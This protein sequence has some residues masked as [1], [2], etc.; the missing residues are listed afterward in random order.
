MNLGELIRRT[1]TSLLAVAV[2]GACDGGSNASTGPP[3]PTCWVVGDG[4]VWDV[5]WSPNGS[6]L[7]IAI[8]RPDASAVI[9]KVD[10]A[11]HQLTVVDDAE[12][13]VPLAVSVDD[14]G[15][16]F[17]FGNP[18][19]RD[20]IYRDDLGE[21]SWSEFDHG[22]VSRAVE[23]STSGLYL[24]RAE[25]VG[26]SEEVT[27]SKVDVTGDVAVETPLRRWFGGSGL[28]VSA[29]GETVL[30]AGRPV[31]GDPV[32]MRVL[33]P[34]GD[35]VFSLE[36]VSPDSIALARIGAD[37]YAY[38]AVGPSDSAGSTGITRPGTG[39]VLPLDGLLALDFS[40]EGRY[41]AGVFADSGQTA[42]LCVGHL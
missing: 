32:E 35:Q 41:A 9:A 8:A 22:F 27:L 30:V 21:R 34:T 3:S 31:P 36:D 14:R 16:V 19:D 33:E 1:T 13:V 2:V 17:Y 42:R 18:S 20:L 28:T 29:D 23:S 4:S 6:H 15:G 7:A 11:S 26:D 37:Q 5:D 24:L 12:D 10:P 39:P 40:Q 25:P 38:Y